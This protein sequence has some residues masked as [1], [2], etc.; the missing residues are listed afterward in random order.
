MVQVTRRDVLLGLALT[1]IAPGIARATAPTVSDQ[2]RD[3][4]AAAGGRLGVAALDLNS[5]TRWTYRA[6]ELFALCSTFKLLAAAYVLARV[7]RGQE[8][9][10]RRVVF[11]GLD[12]VD[13]SPT[14]VQHIGA[15]GLDMAALCEAAVTLSDNT[16]ANLI[17]ASFGGPAAL[18]AYLRT[19]GDSV[20]RL[21]R[22]ETDLNE[23]IPGDPRDTTSP[24]AMLG[25][26]QKLL[27]GNALSARSRTQ[28][29]AWLKA[30]ETGDNRLRAGFP[31]E[32]VVG[33]KTGTGGFNTTNDVA[34][35]WPPDR[36]P[37][38]I[39][40]YYTDSPGQPAMREYVLAEVARTITAQ[41][42]RS[43]RR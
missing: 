33:D 31:V 9:L 40:C 8:N 22:I 39:T 36:A 18:T 2:L 1:G 14:T 25:L 43:E 34:I 29:N 12:V 10:T 23:A 37:V 21:D 20:T 16:A 32:W 41:I 17:L 13:Y 27:V 30:S 35:A 11:S 3:L 26:M 19:L 24:A 28:L 5:H 4:E 38:L 42:V 15:P 6:D 7:D